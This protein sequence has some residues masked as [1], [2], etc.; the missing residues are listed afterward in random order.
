M[1][2]LQD[3]IGYL[4]QPDGD[5][6]TAQFQY[7]EYIFVLGI[8][9]AEVLPFQFMQPLFIHFFWSKSYLERQKRCMS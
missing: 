2:Q 6:K 3:I 9:P 1:N 5:F 7:A 4:Q 8:L